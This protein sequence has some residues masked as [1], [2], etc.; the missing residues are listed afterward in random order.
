VHTSRFSTTFGSAAAR[1]EKSNN[2]SRP[3]QISAVGTVRSP[4]RVVST[5]RDARHHMHARVHTQRAQQHALATARQRTE[6]IVRRGMRAM[7]SDI[8]FWRAMIESAVASIT[9]TLML[10]WFAQ[11]IGHV[12]NVCCDTSVF[13]CARACVQNAPKLAM[14]RQLNPV[15]EHVCAGATWVE[16]PVNNST[17]RQH[18]LMRLTRGFP[19]VLVKLRQAAVGLSPLHQEVKHRVGEVSK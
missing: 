11:R 12:F 5:T 1:R 7:S 14:A 10:L 9:S 16:T 17:G 4:A 18:S 8:R 6:R 2:E 13:M 3:P 19:K 15:R